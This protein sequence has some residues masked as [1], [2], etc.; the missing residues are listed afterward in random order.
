MNNELSD[1]YCQAWSHTTS[2]SSFCAVLVLWRTWSNCHWDTIWPDAF[3]FGRP[4][5]CFT[6]WDHEAL[7]HQFFEPSQTSSDTCLVKPTWVIDSLA[8]WFLIPFLLLPSQVLPWGKYFCSSTV[9]WSSPGSGSRTITH[10]VSALVGSASFIHYSFKKCK[11][12]G[13]LCPFVF[14]P[15]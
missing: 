7:L 13:N 8:G 10:K 6:M 12:M 4:E 15:P 1:V 3:W 9:Y 11:T 5:I 14:P 2:A